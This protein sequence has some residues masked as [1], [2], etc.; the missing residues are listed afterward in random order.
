VPRRASRRRPSR[1]LDS[2]PAPLPDADLL[3]SIRRLR[4][5]AFDADEVVGAAFLRRPDAGGAEVL[6]V[7]ADTVWRTGIWRDLA[8][9]R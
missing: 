8:I 3:G 6:K 4:A 9:E 7:S 1:L 2:A 5:Q